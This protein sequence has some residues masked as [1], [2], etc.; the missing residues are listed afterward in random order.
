METST[1][2]NLPIYQ[3]QTPSDLAW[4]AKIVNAINCIRLKNKKRVTSQRIFSFINKGAL[5]LDCQKFN[6]ILCDMEIDG[7]IYKNGSGKNASFFVNNYFPLE[8]VSP[9]KNLDLTVDNTH[10]QSSRSFASSKSVA[11]PD[12]LQNLKD[13]IDSDLGGIHSATPIIHCVKTPLLQTEGTSPSVGVNYLTDDI[14]WRE[15]I[16]FLRRELENKQKTIDKLFNILR[17]N[18]NEVTK[19]FFLHNNSDEKELS[20]NV[21]TN[22]S[23]INI[24]NNSSIA[25]STKDQ[26]ISTANTSEALI[27][28]NDIS[29]KYKIKNDLKNTTNNNQNL[30]NNVE[31]VRK[32]AINV[33]NQLKE[34][35]KS[36]H[37]RYQ[38]SQRKPNNQNQSECKVEDKSKW[39]KN[40]ALIVGDSMI[41]GIDQQGLSV[42][43][44]IVKV[45]SFPGATI[46][47]MYDYIRPLLKKAPNNVILHV[48][49]NDT[50]NNT[51]R[52]IL[53]NL[54]S[55]K[56]FIEKTLPQLKVCISNIV[57]RTDN[58]KATL[59]VNKV[60]EHLSA[61]KLDIVDNANINVTSLNCGGLHLNK[62][63]TGKLAVNFI[64]KIKSFKRQ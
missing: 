14:L 49:T 50:P 28:T 4:Q 62:T 32:N 61:L 36:M 23:V 40:T 20:E 5:Q 37:L 48:G 7:K 34:I 38:N 63:G 41:S 21:M 22:N 33:E 46:N 1:E 55:L 45:R 57:Q 10:S 3:L 8:A 9:V 16:L 2:K 29:D 27:I 15:E 6:D 17:N 54:L 30:D 18:N 60:N 25:N 26:S 35:R 47:D 39:R 24:E 12:T 52:A 42:K 31:R 59:T 19:Q 58:G 44:R 53:D 51:S 43:G 13:V 64:K 56:S 11:T